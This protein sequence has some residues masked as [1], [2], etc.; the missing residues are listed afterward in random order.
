MPHPL[1]VPREGALAVLVVRAGW[2][3]MVDYQREAGE[4]GMATG[5]GRDDEA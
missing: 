2:D 4:M 3:G 5:Q 1:Y